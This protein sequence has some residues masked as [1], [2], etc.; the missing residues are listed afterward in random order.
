VTRAERLLILA[1]A[2]RAAELWACGQEERA[3]RW[4]DAAIRTLAGREFID[5]EVST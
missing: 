4:I 1:C 3:D 2:A 5:D